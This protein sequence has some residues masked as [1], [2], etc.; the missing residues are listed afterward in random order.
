MKNELKPKIIGL[1]DEYE[2]KKQELTQKAQSGK[3]PMLSVIRWH[4]IEVYDKVIRDL[5]ELLK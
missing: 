1:K 3:L 2:K 5:E 4:K